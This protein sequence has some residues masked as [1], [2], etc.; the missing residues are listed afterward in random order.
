MANLKRQAET[1]YGQLASEERVH[2]RRECNGL[3]LEFRSCTPEIS[4][5][6]F[7]SL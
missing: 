6:P 5:I 3:N 1:W 2:G 4:H 7:V